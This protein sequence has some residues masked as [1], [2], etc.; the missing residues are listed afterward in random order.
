MTNNRVIYLTHGEVIVLASLLLDE[1][2]YLGDIRD[3]ARTIKD[4]DELSAAAVA[5]LLL[6]AK[7]CSSCRK[8]TELGE[9]LRGAKFCNRC[10]KTTATRLNRGPAIELPLTAGDRDFFH[11]CGIA[12]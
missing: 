6:I 8:W 5:D 7:I 3:A 12:P 11:A 4:G 9:F 2:Y 10:L 1:V